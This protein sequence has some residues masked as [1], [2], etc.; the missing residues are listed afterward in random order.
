MVVSSSSSDYKFPDQKKKNFQN[1]LAF[2]SL[3][4]GRLFV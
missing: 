4:G 1:I 2:S 3:F